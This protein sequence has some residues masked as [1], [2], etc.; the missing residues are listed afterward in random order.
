[1]L[2]RSLRETYLFS[3]LC[4]CVSIL[5]VISLIPLSPRTAIAEEDA[6]AEATISELLSAGEYAEGEVIV[7]MDTSV[8]AENGVAP[9]ARQ[10]DLLSSAEELMTTTNQVYEEVTGEEIADEAVAGSES[11]Q[12]ATVSLFSRGLSVENIS[13]RYLSNTGLSTEELL[14]TFINDSRVLSVEPNYTGQIAEQNRSLSVQARISP[15]DIGDL[16]SIQWGNKNDDTAFYTS[17]LQA[18]Q[19]TVV[20]FDINDVSWNNGNDNAT[21]AV[22]VVD[23]GIDYTH[24]DLAPSMQGSM[25][26][27]VSYG[28]DYG[29]NATGIGDAADSSDVHGHGTHCAGTIA[30]AWNDFGTSGV[31]S[32]AKLVAVRI[33]DENGSVSMAAA[34]RGYQYLADAMDNGL[35]LKS[36][37]NSWGTT[38]FGT[39]FSLAV[40]DAG[41]RGAVSVF[42]S[43]NASSNIDTTPDSGAALHNNPYAV[44]VNSATSRQTL[45]SFSNYGRETTNIV[46]PGSAIMSTA[47]LWQSTYLPDALKANGSVSNISYTGFTAGGAQ[48]IGFYNNEDRINSV[49]ERSTESYFN[50]DGASWFVKASD[51]KDIS[52]DSMSMKKLY[53]QIEVPEDKQDEVRYLGLSFLGLGREGS[54]SVDVSVKAKNDNGEEVFIGKETPVYCNDWN[55]VTLDLKSQPEKKVVYEGGKFLYIE[56]LVINAP[57]AASFENGLLID[58]VALGPEGSL[59]PYQFMSGTSM[60]A[61]HATGAAAVLATGDDLS[62]SKSEQ[63]LLRAA[64]LE[65][66]IRDVPAFN[67]LCTS[68]GALDLGIDAAG[69]CAPVLRTASVDS[70]SGVNQVTLNGY[71]FGNTQGSVTVG[72]LPATITSW[73]DR[74]VTLECPESLHS[75][76]LEFVLTSTLNKTAKKTFML[77]LVS[78]PAQ[79]ATPL[80]EYE[81]DLPMSQEGFPKFVNNVS[82]VGLGGN[83]Y[84]FPEDSSNGALYQTLWR[85]DNQSKEW[86]RCADLPVPL[87]VLSTTTYGGK[88]L[89]AGTDAPNATAKVYEYDS[90]TNEFSDLGTPEGMTAYT[91]LV[92]CNETLLM[93]GGGSFQGGGFLPHDSVGVYNLET[94][95]VNEVAK[96]G[97]ASVGLQVVAHGQDVFVVEVNTN[98]TAFGIR[99]ISLLDYSV[100]DRSSSLPAFIAG[101]NN[102]TTLASLKQGVAL[103]GSSAQSAKRS[104]AG[105]EDQDTYVASV[106]SI[107]QGG[108]FEPFN[109]RLSSAPIINVKA[110]THR[111]MM[112]A[113]GGSYYEE[114]NYVLRA[115]AAETLEQPGDLYEIAYHNVE[116]AEHSNPTHYSASYLPLTL[117]APANRANETFAGWYETADFTGEALTA[118]PEGTTGDVQLWA[119]WEAS[120][121]PVDEKG[122]KLSETGD[123]LPLVPIIV[124][125]CVA[126]AVVVIALWRIRKS[127]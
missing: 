46:A 14:R 28:G 127:K 2:K 67:S 112:Y 33:G 30:S 37:N 57:G 118:L 15:S 51:M 84:C 105:L 26:A 11:D 16:T 106:D 42:A 78:P 21:G 7:V 10:M 100:S 109:K 115:T 113:F 8:Q 99:Q 119:K 90:L 71:F 76:T 86:S 40:T 56:I 75:G 52:F 73:S 4:L 19:N 6:S 29:Y 126:L 59:V 89:I 122:D 34:L 35:E 77:E 64:R 83:L 107:S 13:V 114:D 25:K 9:R 41:K 72:G 38:C 48:N 62:Q 58:S 74:S 94:N 1:M 54:C 116:A 17:G 3:V 104:T 65:G 43:G 120:V 44:A 61:P 39:A 69:T 123:S 103:V 91:A 5:L 27:F 20:D 55:S 110:T 79:A 22:A 23:T 117:A 82:L 32:G 31:A 98:G 124:F 45:S 87:S 80:Y 88:V 36:I 50:D 108:V 96:L 93:I 53:A 12:G 121:S 68:G 102:Y 70:S 125:A 97:E 111:G 18:G 92:N 66:S 60:A 47:P 24:P 101:Q 95:E 63:A 81:I 49:G 85:Y